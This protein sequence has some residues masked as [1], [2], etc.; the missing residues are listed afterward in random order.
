M[1]SSW[2]I[3]KVL[4]TPN[5]ASFYCTKSKLFNYFFLEDQLV[6]KIYNFCTLEPNKIKNY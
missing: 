6:K 2:S 5:F 1:L 3:V 4:L